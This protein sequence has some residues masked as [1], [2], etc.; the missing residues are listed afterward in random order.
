MRTEPDPLPPARRTLP[1]MLE[2]QAALFGDKPLLSIAGRQWVHADARAAAASR[3]GALAAAGVERGDRVALMSGN[4]LEVLETLGG[5][6]WL[7]AAMVPINTASMAP[8]IEYFLADSAARLLVIES[9]FLDRLAG[10]DLART[11]LRTVWVTGE[12]EIAL[13]GVEVKAWPA[14]GEAIAAAEV[15]PGDTLAI[16]YTSGTTGPAKG[17]D[18]KSVV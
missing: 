7:G 13:E 6:G 14:D 4:R 2:R 12:G 8:Q 16:L 9:A 1:A 5:C 10:V 11:A 18:R 17:V 3:A 15:Q